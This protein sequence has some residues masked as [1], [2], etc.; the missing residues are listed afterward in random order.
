MEPW[1]RLADTCVVRH[2]CM[3]LPL[4]MLHTGQAVQCLWV[5]PLP[6][7]KMFSTCVL[8]LC[9]IGCKWKVGLP[10]SVEARQLITL[11]P[12]YYTTPLFK[13]SSPSLPLFKWERRWA[14]KFS[15]VL[16]HVLFNMMSDVLR[17]VLGASS[18]TKTLDVMPKNT[19]H[20]L[21][22]K[23]SAI[24]HSCENLPK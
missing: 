23:Q 19:G 3:S 2:A 15:D 14:C 5:F 20:N 21:V 6:V 17:Y 13:K 16:Y 18:G 24:N 12:D 22:T 10:F 4:A 7:F 11:Q 1:D 9:T 8:C